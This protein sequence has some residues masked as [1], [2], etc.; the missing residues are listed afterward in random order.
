MRNQ[1]YT[2]ATLEV[3]R[4]DIFKCAKCMIILTQSRHVN[5]GQ[6]FFFKKYI[7]LIE[8]SNN[9]FHINLTEIISRFLTCNN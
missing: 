2:N 8:A 5:L 3:R 7:P 4:E 1:T 9:K 6:F